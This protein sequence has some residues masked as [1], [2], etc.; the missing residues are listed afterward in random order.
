MIIKYTSSVRNSY[1]AVCGNHTEIT[2]RSYIFIFDS[3]V[4]GY[5]RNHLTDDSPVTSI[6]SYII[7]LG[8]SVN[9]F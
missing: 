4:P 1:F 9:E 8:S 7:M 6:V 2:A 3:E 5:L